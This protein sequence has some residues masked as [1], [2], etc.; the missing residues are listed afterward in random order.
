MAKETRLVTFQPTASDVLIQQAEERF[1]NGRK[2]YKSGNLEGARSEFDLAISL[3]LRASEN[4]TSRTLFESRLEEMVDSI[5][6][7]DLSGLGAAAAQEVPG[8]DKAPLDD[9]VTTTFPVDPRIKDKVQSEVKLTTSA[10]P[11]VVNDTVLSYINFFN[12]PRG[13]KTIEAGIERAGRYQ[14]M[15]SRILAE[16]G[17]PQELIHVAQAES[18]FLPRAVSRAAATGMWQFVKFRGNEYGLMQTPYSDDRLDPEKATRAAARHLHDLYREFGDWYL[19]IAAYN[20]GPGAVERAVERTGYADFWE[21]RDRGALP[22]ETTNYVPIILAMTIMEKNASAYGL[23]RVVPDAPIQY[24]TIHTVSPTNLAL[25]ADLTDTSVS[26]LLQLNP[27][28]LRSMAPGDFEI[29]VPKGAGQQVTAALDLIPAERRASWRSHR[30]EQ[31]ET[32]ASVAK[33]FNVSPGQLASANDLKDD[34]APGDR[35]MV[36]AAYHEPAAPARTARTV[37]KHASTAVAASRKTMPR[38]HTTTTASVRRPVHPTGSTLAQVK[39]Q[40][41]SLSR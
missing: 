14:A 7:D 30:V 36:P 17:L 6:R 25:V 3:M 15:V 27:A 23:D 9:I 35:L 28:L 10:L 2:F 13:H 16:E 32:L 31:G 33:L 21:L 34:L 26:E 5:H 8:F 40:S 19:A 1:Q 22:K 18:G 24:D 20:C 29:R 41:R 38:T 11:L 39:N 37:V 4:P 12:G